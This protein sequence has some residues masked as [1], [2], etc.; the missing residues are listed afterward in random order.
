MVAAL[1]V[2]GFLTQTR[3]TPADDTTP[4]EHLQAASRQS[5]EITR[6]EREDRPDSWLLATQTWKTFWLDFS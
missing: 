6:I 2:N 3:L 1:A 5:R 4:E